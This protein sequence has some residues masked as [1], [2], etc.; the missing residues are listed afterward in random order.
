MAY[1]PLLVPSPLFLN[2]LPKGLLGSHN[3]HFYADK[4]AVPSVAG[5]MDRESR[6]W[7]HSPGA[8]TCHLHTGNMAFF[9]GRL[10]FLT[11]K[12]MGL[13]WKFPPS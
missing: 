7:Q 3:C 6:G 2:P 8:A 9:L 13:E 1:L 5:A 4:K 12:M 10:S 11:G